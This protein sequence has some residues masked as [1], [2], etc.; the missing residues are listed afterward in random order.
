[1]APLDHRSSVLSGGANEELN[2]VRLLLHTE[3]TLR[4]LGLVGSRNASVTETRCERKYGVGVGREETP[5]GGDGSII[6]LECTVST[7]RRVAEY[8]G[9]SG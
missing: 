9:G 5:H 3:N 4:A 8:H 6:S 7:V 2:G 1:M